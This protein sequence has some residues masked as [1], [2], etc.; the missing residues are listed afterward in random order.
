MEESNIRFQLNTTL[1]EELHLAFREF[2]CFEMPHGKKQM[3]KALISF[4]TLELVVVITLIL[5]G[6]WNIITATC[7]ILTGIYTVICA[8]FYK[9]ITLRKF[10]KEYQQL[11]KQGDVPLPIE[12][13]V[14][15]YDDR[16]VDITP[17]TRIEDCYEGLKQICVVEGKFILLYFNRG[18]THIFPVAQLAEQVDQEEFLN[19]LSEKC[20]NVTYH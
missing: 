19:F 10:K 8:A 6:G 16:L 12:S 1:T 14:E 17:T 20:T 7:T 15:I 5:I 18:G 3:R 11:K 4:V 13:R 2:D 9:K